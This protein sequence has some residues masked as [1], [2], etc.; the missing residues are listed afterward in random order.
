[1]DDPCDILIKCSSSVVRKHAALP[2]AKQNKTGDENGRTPC[3]NLAKQLRTCL[4]HQRCLLSAGE[5]D[6]YS[7]CECAMYCIMNSI[8]PSTVTSNPS[9]LVLL[10]LN[11][12]TCVYCQTNQATRLACIRR[13]ERKT[14]L[15]IARQVYIGLYQLPNSLARF[16]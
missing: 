2:Y 12:N 8:Y 15:P 7:P 14:I 4:F 1:M 9:K 16:A 10:F 11:T 6:K 5:L 3:I 13:T